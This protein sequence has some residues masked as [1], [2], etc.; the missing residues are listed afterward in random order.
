VAPGCR[1]SSDTL[2]GYIRT[3]V[4]QPLLNH[5]RQLSVRQEPCRDGGATPLMG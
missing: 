4:D 3:V 5:G 1:Q 2:R